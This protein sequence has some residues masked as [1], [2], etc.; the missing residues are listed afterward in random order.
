MDV[1]GTEERNGIA[2][3]RPGRVTVKMQIYY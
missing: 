1:I 2:R 3:Y